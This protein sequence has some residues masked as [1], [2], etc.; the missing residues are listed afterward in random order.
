MNNKTAMWIN[1]AV[2]ILWIGIALRELFA[3]HLFTF[4]PSVASNSTI[5]LDFAAGVVFLFVAFCFQRT[6][7]HKLQNKSH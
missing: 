2:G 7:L 1:A 3:P 4:S 5:I 6:G